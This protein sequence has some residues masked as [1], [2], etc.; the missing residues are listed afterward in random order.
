MTAADAAQKAEEARR[1]AEAAL[2]RHAQSVI[3]LGGKK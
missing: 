3:A 2:R 1:E